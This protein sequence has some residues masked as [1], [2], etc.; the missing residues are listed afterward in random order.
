MIQLLKSKLKIE[1]VPAL[2]PHVTLQKKQIT[3]EQYGSDLPINESAYHMLKQIDGKKTEASITKELTELFQVDESIIARDFY[4]LLLGMNQHYLVSIHYQ[5]PYALVTTLCQFFKQYQLKRNER[6]ECGSQ[7]FWSIFTTCLAMVTRKIIFFWFMFMIMVGI[8]Y[9]FV[10]DASIVAIAIY[11]SII[12]FGLITGTALH[13]AAHGYSH[14]KFAGPDGPQGFFASDM[15][16]VKFVRPVLDPFHKKLVWITILGPLVPGIL[17]AIGIMV[18]FLFL[19]ENPISTGFFIFSI[20]YFIQLLYLLPF[21][22]DGKS[23]M[24]QLLLGGMGGQRS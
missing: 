17:G 14:R 18:T 2:S 19:K 4:K 7:S 8:A 23:I 13:E 20:T 11:F 12:Y 10:P 9:M 21:M 5:S 22:G 6:Y 15:M 1:R 24:K 16:S 3:D